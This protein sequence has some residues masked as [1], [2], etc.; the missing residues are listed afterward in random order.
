MSTIHQMYCTHCTHGSSALQR[1]QGELADRMLGY[2]A[3]GGSLEAGPLRRCY[4]Q[5]ER[6]VYYYLPR[7]TPT[8]A[9]LGLDA[10]SAPRRLVYLPSADG[11]PLVAQVC[12]RPTDTQGRPGSY[13]A[14]VL[15]RQQRD[16]QPGF[17]SL[18][19]LKL[20][21]APGWVEEDSPEIPF[22][23]E[24]LRSLDDM[25]GRRR[26]AVDD[27][28]LLGFLQSPP[29]GPFDDPGGV[30]P[31]RWRQ[32]PAAERTALLRDALLGFLQADG[33]RRESLLLVVEPPVAA[34]VFYGIVRLLPE[35]SL[36]EGI[37][38]STFEPNTD[39]LCTTLAATQFHDSQATDLRP[40]VYRSGSPVINTFLGRRSE[41]RPGESPYAEVVL[42]RLLEKGWAAVDHTLGAMRTAGA[43]RI[44][45][46][47]RLAA[48]DRVV[49]VLLRTGQS[50]AGRPWRSS[51]VAKGYLQQALGRAL[52]ELSAP[53]AQL[54][55]LVGRPAQLAILE[56]AAGRTALPGTEAAVQF[57]L[58]R[59]PKERIAELLT[60]EDVA[61]Q[62]KADVLA[63]YVA[64]H[65]ELPPGC[66]ALWTEAAR[67]PKARTRA[68]DELLLPQVL[69][70]LD[71][72]TLERFYRN[73]A[74]RHGPHFFMALR[75]S[76]SHKGAERVP[77]TRIVEAM[78]DEALLSLLGSLG[79][80]FLKGYPADEPALGRRLQGILR[81]LPEH[82]GQFQA[83]LDVILAGEHL[84]P[85][86]ADRRVAA[87]WGA[88]CQAILQIG[89]LQ[90]QKSGVL[91]RAPT[92]R[93]EDACRSMS[94]AAAAAMPPDRFPD[95]RRG[96][97]KQ[98]VLR[99]IGPRVLG[100]KKLLPPGPW[101]H[102][103][104]WQKI[105]WHFET[106][107]WPS[108]P[109]AKMRRRSASSARTRVVVGAVVALGLVGSVLGFWVLPKL[110]Q[111]ETPTP[112]DPA[113]AVGQNTPATQVAAGPATGRDAQRQAAP[114]EPPQQ[115]TAPPSV[116][117]EE[118][119]RLRREEEARL[120]EHEAARVAAAEQ[121]AAEAAAAERE[122]KW[123]AAA[124]WFAE[125]NHGRFFEALPVTGGDAL[126]PEPIPPLVTPTRLYLGTGRLVFD[127]QAYP[128]GAGFD[129]VPPATRQE[130]PQLAEKLGLRS[131]YVEIQ[132]RD[133]GHVLA[134]RG[135]QK[136][137][138]DP[139]ERE[140]LEDLRRRSTQLSAVVY[141]LPGGGE[142]PQNPMPS[143]NLS[144]PL[145][146]APSQAT[147]PVVPPAKPN[148]P[149][150]AS[151][152][153]LKIDGQ[154]KVDQAPARG[155]AATTMARIRP[156]VLSSTGRPVPGWF[157]ST[158]VVG[159]RIREHGAGGSV[160]PL[161]LHNLND[162]PVGELLD[163][164][165]KAEI[166]F[167]F[168]LPSGD[169]LGTPREAAATGWHAIVPIERGQQYTIKLGL[170]PK[171]L[172]SLRKL[173]GQ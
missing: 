68:D 161:D 36:R 132:P 90:N 155:L 67:P 26:P 125:Q 140:A 21:G 63:R 13:F 160:R 141:R 35:G 167:R 53:E 102:A 32:K 2:S 83:R 78:D 50:P 151:A 136:A 121:A 30:I 168:L 144:P 153:S 60:L 71:L 19:C 129:R 10:S 14:H 126:L 148:T 122:K 54:A 87:A 172:E 40:E 97:R 169:L 124:K 64:A 46:L 118:A 146:P 12:Y 173:A 23:L 48:V 34:L 101:Q 85:E 22:L 108:A 51:P 79:P 65:A 130:V 57:L 52:G 117:A 127:G 104:L 74:G 44:D 66:E 82:L 139:A 128:F 159:C 171:Q 72:K 39:R 123:R 110:S 147:P 142:P 135:Q 131:V 33:S 42:G 138:A 137:A 152:A 143:E 29:G 166:Q 134:I 133:A 94:E 111:R 116:S 157:K 70:R 93:L 17:S 162:Q 154:Y 165:S 170:T 105:L 8:E 73:V 3:R 41:P 86:P 24:P 59:L 158:Y 75:E 113:G 99:K 81:T 76:C 145:K 7:D 55:A 62:R 95:D 91:R 96:T 120:A 88:C 119:A 16:G 61:P 80:G 115:K 45:D 58:A 164:T 18:E 112:N 9:K 20:W 149:R 156:I 150:P 1:Q 47:Q 92:D 107:E 4:R 43:R 77:L 56:L 69:A 5:I 114:V 49:P 31:A 103:A 98:E 15:F 109:L 27:D 38:F 37:S 106:G 100:G 89:E 11:L 25:F 163:G 28:V 84:L 6:Y